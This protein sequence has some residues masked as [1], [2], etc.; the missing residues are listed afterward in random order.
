MSIEKPVVIKLSFQDWYVINEAL[1]QYEIV[2]S[3][4]R[5][6]RYY[7]FLKVRSRF[8]KELFNSVQDTVRSLNRD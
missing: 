7:D 3:A 4:A 1:A 5:E 8:F 2:L 6:Q